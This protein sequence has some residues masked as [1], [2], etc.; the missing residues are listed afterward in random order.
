MENYGSGSKISLIEWLILK[1]GDADLFTAM[2]SFKI[3]FSLI[4]HTMNNK[5]IYYGMLKKCEALV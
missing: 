4:L 5:K 1:K 2:K 3:F